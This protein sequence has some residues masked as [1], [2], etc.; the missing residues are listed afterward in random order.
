MA[1]I[2]KKEKSNPLQSLRGL[3][4]STSYEVFHSA[5]TSVFP[6]TE[7]VLPSSIKDDT[8]ILVR[9]VGQTKDPNKTYH[10][11]DLIFDSRSTQNWYFYADRDTISEWKRLHMANELIDEL[12]IIK[13]KFK[14]GNIRIEIKLIRLEY[15][16]N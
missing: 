15:N 7:S 13:E 5:V 12:M 8:E 2:S 9:V 16:I 11:R 3:S 10:Y 1:R 6:R 14:E 4:I